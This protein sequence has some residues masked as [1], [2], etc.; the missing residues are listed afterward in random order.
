MTRKLRD[1]ATSRREWRNGRRMKI[2]YL[3]F[4]LVVL[5]GPT[6]MSFERQIRFVR[7][8]PLA[9]AA[10]AIVAV[11]YIL[12]DHAVTGRHWDF[13]PAFTLI[14]LWDLP[15]GEWLFFLSV[16]FAM[17]FLWEVITFYRNGEQPRESLGLFRKIVIVLIGPGAFIFS[18]GLEYTGLVLIALGFSAFIDMNLHTEVF[19]QP[20]VFV[21]MAISILATTIFNM[22]LTGRPVVLYGEEYQ[23]SFR[24]ISIP[25][26]DYFYGLAHLT[27]VATVYEALK[28]FV[29]KRRETRS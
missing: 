4:N 16:P 21:Y 29:D 5:A 1:C 28:G 3:L 6:A 11:P 26:E 7:R 10:A 20:R 12:W 2:E 8:W 18:F 14:R 9:I 27:L 22:Y 15:V 13:N 17:L 25:V 19:L 24:I 23:L